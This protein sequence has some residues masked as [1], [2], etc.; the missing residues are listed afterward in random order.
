MEERGPDRDGAWELLC[1]YTKTDSL[2]KHALA[3]EAAMRAYAERFGED[4][5]AWGIVGLLHDFD[6]ERWPDAENHPYRGEEILRE[7]GFPDAWRRAILGHASYT[8]V[9]RDS[10]MARALFAVD[11]LCGFISAVTLVRP[12]RSLIDVDVR[13]V[14]KKMKERGF[15]RSV[16]REEIVQGAEELGVDLDAHIDFVLASLRAIAG[17]IGLAGSAS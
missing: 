15:A 4:A 6:Y 3:V 9:P 12:S 17:S 14:R 1:S 2:R 11:E 13:S 7:H 8:G 5:D 16:N 10:L